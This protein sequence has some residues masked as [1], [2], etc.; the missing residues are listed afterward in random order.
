MFNYYEFKN[1][2]NITYLELLKP[3]GQSLGEL[4]NA[5]NKVS[6]ISL[7]EVSEL[8]FTLPNVKE[9][10]M[11]NYGDMTN[12][13]KSSLFSKLENYPQP[14]IEDIGKSS[15]TLVGYQVFARY[16]NGLEMIFT[17]PNRTITSDMM[18]VDISFTCYS[19]EHELARKLI[20]DYRGVLIDDKYTLDALTLEEV[21][22][23]LL[24]GTIW[25]LDFLDVGYNNTD[26]NP[27]RRT[28][29]AFNNVSLL[30]AL[31][32]ISTVF[33][34]IPIY[35]T[36][37]RKVSFYRAD[38]EEYFKYNGLLIDSVN[39]MNNVKEQKTTDELITRLYGIGANN[40]TIN[41]VNPAGVSY[42]EDLSFFIYPAKLNDN[43]D[44]LIGHSKYMSDSLAL[45]E[46]LYEEKVADTTITF[47]ELYEEKD[48][49]QSELII[50]ENQLTSLKFELNQIQDYIDVMFVGNNSA[51]EDNQDYVL[52]RDE[53]D[54]KQ[55]EIEAKQLEI[56]NKKAEISAINNQL[57]DLYDDLKIENNFTEEEIAERQCFIYEG[58]Y[59]NSGIAIAEDLY[60]EMVDFLNKKK[61][62]NIIIETN[63]N[64]ILSMKSKNAKKDANKIMVG[65]KIDLY[66]NYKGIDIDI[67]AQILAITIDEENNSLDLVISNT[68]D[69]K[70]SSTDYLENIL[71]RSITTSTIVDNNI[72]D[73]NKGKIAI[74]ELD[75]IYQNGIDTAKIQIEG[76]SDNSVRFNER[77]LTILNTT[78]P[79]R[80]LRATNGVLALTKDGGRTYSTAITPEGIWAER[81]IGQILLGS[82]LIIESTDINTSLKISDIP[83]G[84]Y[85]DVN[86]DLN[87]YGDDFG[88]VVKGPNNLIFVSRERGFKITT[89]SG[90][91]LFEAK[92]N[93]ILR[94]KGLEIISQDGYS[95]LDGVN[96]LQS[97]QDTVSDSCDASHPVYQYVYIPAETASIRTAKLSLRRLN[98]RAY[99]TATGGGGASTQS[100]TSSG[101]GSYGSTVDREGNGT[102]AHQHTI[103]VQGTD[104]SV[105]NAEALGYKIL[106]INPGGG[107]N[108]GDCAFGAAAGGKIFASN[109]AGL[110]NS[111][112]PKTHCTINGHTHY[113]SVPSHTHNVSIDI[114]SHTHSISYGISEQAFSGSVTVKVGSTTIGTYG[115]DQVAIDIKN[116]L[117]AGSWNTITYTPSGN[118]RVQS[119]IFIQA[120]IGVPS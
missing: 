64:N 108:M 52:K 103:Q 14:N 73:W 105:S 77:G 43:K 62:P 15:I 27:I 22:R 2:D 101:G 117:V 37:N 69:Y 26:V 45:A 30:A 67:R 47:Q 23:D 48:T 24:G 56:N 44:G 92:T 4:K 83:S 9:I 5:Y 7:G 31:D 61:E 59:T 109:A 40:L 72:I 29:D 46:L 85:S 49:K 114:P 18:K 90:V 79:L 19:R 110:L 98:Y 82:E 42:I 76:A 91:T 25:E 68:Q 34:A 21:S 17:I 74:D 63:I 99:S 71:K 112:T 3:N 65:E 88:I 20:I 66:Y 16:S 120:M 87:P 38:N 36:I 86:S 10:F 11:Q 104:T 111:L 53:L 100:T 35:D 84:T 50:L 113:F 6:K 57:S 8:S 28:V 116:Y 94:A 32:N 60:D 1:G 81:L 95:I 51:T 41:G 13:E 102:S 118:A 96:I 39:Y 75:G 55:D 80:F 54:D 58:L 115:S 107:G 33:G 89:L 97:W 119:T 78:E 106:M 70:K 12:E 93:G